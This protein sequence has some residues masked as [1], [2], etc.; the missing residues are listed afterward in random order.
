MEHFIFNMYRKCTCQKTKN[1]KLKIT[2]KCV[3]EIKEH[4]W[5][6]TILLINLRGGMTFSQIF[7]VYIIKNIF[8]Y[9]NIKVIEIINI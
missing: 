5:N 2:S 3:Y 8:S 6:F 1:F 7:F 9:K 4:N